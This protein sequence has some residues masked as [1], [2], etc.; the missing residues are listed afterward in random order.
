MV[1][2]STVFL[3]LFLPVVL[4]LHTVAPRA[5]KNTVLLV[6]SLIFYF[7]GEKFFVLVMLASIAAN[8]VFGLLIDR[9]RGRA[10]CIGSDEQSEVEH[11]D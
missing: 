2:S 6:A 3:F 11:R 1:F 10:R 7:W 5:L 9:W 4:L 8:Y